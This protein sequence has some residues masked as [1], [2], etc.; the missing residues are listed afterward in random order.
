MTDSS[1][2]TVYSL[3]IERARAGDIMAARA[4]L[5]TVLWYLEH[6]PESRLPESLRLYLISAVN[7][8]INPEPLKAFLREESKKGT[9]DRSGKDSVTILRMVLAEI[10]RAEEGTKR[11]MGDANRAFHLKKKRGK[12]LR[13]SSVFTFESAILHV[14]V[15]AAMDAGR[16]YQDAVGDVA[17]AEGVSESTVHRAWEWRDQYHANKGELLATLVKNGLESGKTLACGFRPKPATQSDVNP[18]TDSDSKA[19]TR[20]GAKAATCSDVKAATFRSSSEG[21]AGLPSE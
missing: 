6:A 10:R 18:A 4:V 11:L 12:G 5:R 15:R 8:I 7:E 16:S 2:D 9:A 13:S 17:S 14:Q 3:D 21:V 20:S 1:E 19:A